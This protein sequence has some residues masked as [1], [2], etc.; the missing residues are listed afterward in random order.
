ML[1]IFKNP[2]AKFISMSIFD[3]NCIQ[4]QTLFSI[5]STRH[6]RRIAPLSLSAF[7]EDHSDSPRLWTRSTI[8]RL[9]LP[10]SAHHK[11]YHSLIQCLF[12]GWG[13]TPQHMA[14]AIKHSSR[15]QDLY[16]S[17]SGIRELRL[18]LAGLGYDV[19]RPIWASKSECHRHL[20]QKCSV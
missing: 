5:R 10:W 19:F 13:T 14:F 2:D 3:S 20:G 1:T 8:P 15:K 6:S 11:D 16:L 9:T 4:T 12:V 17:E 7:L 18:A